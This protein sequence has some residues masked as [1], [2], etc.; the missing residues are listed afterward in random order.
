MHRKSIRAR[1][2]AALFVAATLAGSKSASADIKI[3]NIEGW[4]ISTSGRVNGFFSF[5]RGEAY[6]STNILGVPG[7][8]NKL[9]AGAGLESQQ[10]DADRRFQTLRFRSG[11]L[12]AVLGFGVKTSLT[13]TTTMRAHI[14]T[15]NTI[16]TSR[17]KAA[18][19]PTDVRQAYGKIEGPWGGLLFGRSLALFSRGAITLDFMYQHG[20]GLGYP[21]NADGGGPTCGAV[22][23]GVVFAGFNPQLTY[24]T[25][26][27]G[28]FQLSVGLFDPSNSPGKLEITPLPRLEGEV[29][30][31]QKFSG[32]KFHVFANGMV[33]TLK[34]NWLN[35]H[36]RLKAAGATDDVA[37]ATRDLKSATTRAVNYGFRAEISVVRIGFSS[38]Y[39][40]GIGMNNALENTP[41]V[42][43]NAHDPRKFDA[44]Y[45][46][47]GVDLD[48]VYL[49]AGYGI[50]RLFTTEQD[51][52]DALTAQQ[53]PIKSQRGI[54]AGI[55]YRFSKN[56]VAALE[57]F[58]AD[59]T[60]YLGE[61]QRVQIVNSGLTMV[62]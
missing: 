15:W 23:Y 57:F 36:D 8:D 27:M 17:N 22:G 11:F 1:A 61:T 5:I 33:Q 26:D 43:D 41:V 46:V 14:E 18:P 3:A 42:F 49:N 58:G 55:N 30:F 9:S 16:E 31:E 21:C 29:T 44:Y 51:R 2:I 13:P 4:E 20:F 62:W 19:N 45:G 24:N 32:G 12:G 48:T 59:H 37:N 53:D 38:H 54:S 28:G 25:P 52:Q 60:W 40:Y 6:P 7:T 50:T 56:L 10:Y 34:E 35:A 47:I 39:G